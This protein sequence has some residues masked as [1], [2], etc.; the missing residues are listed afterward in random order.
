MSG[1][2]SFPEAVKLLDALMDG[3]PDTDHLEI[4]TFKKGGG[5]RKQFHK[6]QNLRQ[7]G[8]ETAL[9]AHLDGKKNIY[10]GVTPRYEP[11]KAESDNDRGDAV[12][13]A[14]SLWL[15]EI[16]RPA[17]DLP[18]FSWMVETSLGEVQAG[19]LLKEPTT[20]L[21]R[22]EGLN[23]RLAVAVGGDNVWNRGRVLRLPGFVSLN[24]P[25]VQ[26]SRLIE[27]HPDLRYT[28]NELDQLLP[29]LPNDPPGTGVSRAKRQF[30]R[31]TFDPHWPCPLAP[32]LQDRLVDFL[33]GLNLRVFSDGRYGGS[34]PLPHEG[35]GDCDC[36]QAFY[37]SPISGS[38]S[39]F[40]SD[41]ISQ[42]S[43]TIRDFAVLG[44]VADLTLSEI[45][46]QIG[47][48]H[49]GPGEVRHGGGEP[50]QERDV[51]DKVIAPKALYRK[52]DKP[53]DRGKNSSL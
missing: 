43:G 12:N 37:A 38:W 5:A 17:P 11:R 51:A 9:P 47:R 13:M 23:K 44:F 45:Q 19:Y 7:Q 15:D 10:Y 20:D 30:Q 50:T 40:C 18:R 8:F 28:I 3:V 16:T 27:F 34:C 46:E 21:G 41:P 42:T 35:D 39:C 1:Q 32:S 53:R 29:D 52:C 33:E 26:R 6:L 24:H 4:R 48:D 31:G 2:A 36:D 22:I 14:T 25:G 49:V